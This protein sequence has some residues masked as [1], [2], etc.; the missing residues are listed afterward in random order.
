[1]SEA[2]DRS[3]NERAQAD[4]HAP[5]TGE[6]G[7]DVAAAYL[8]NKGWR[9]LDRNYRFERAELDLVAYEPTASSDAETESS[10]AEYE[11][12]N[13]GGAI[14]IV[15]VKA[16]TGLGFGRPEEAVTQ[17][18]QRHV[19][20][21]ATAYLHER[22]LKDARVRFDVISVLLSR[23]DDA[24]PQIEHFRDAFEATE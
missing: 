10:D 3:S 18:K 19:T 6:R 16:R 8:E 5:K 22:R 2:N 13:G 21:A 23:D 7:E 9:I 15:E 17:E 1:M 24:A 11:E 12:E 4:G 14:V 20:R